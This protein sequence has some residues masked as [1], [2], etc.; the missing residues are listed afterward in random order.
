[1]D[2]F[3]LKVPGNERADLVTALLRG[4]ELPDRGIYPEEDIFFAGVEDRL[5]PGRRAARPQEGA[6]EG[7]VGD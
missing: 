6:A 5:F 7:D 4:V 3:V 2:E 1:M